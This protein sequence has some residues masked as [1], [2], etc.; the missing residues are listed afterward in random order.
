VSLAGAGPNDQ[1]GVIGPVDEVVAVE[2]ADHGLVDLAGGKI[3]AGEV[4]VGRVTFAVSVSPLWRMLPTT[5]IGNA[6]G[7]HVTT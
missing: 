4:L 6:L 2:L 3:E 1:H 7:D 5:V